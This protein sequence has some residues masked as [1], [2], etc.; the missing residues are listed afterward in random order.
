MWKRKPKR[1]KKMTIVVTS[2]NFTHSRERNVKTNGSQT[3]RTTVEMKSIS[4]A[5][6]SQSASHTGLLQHM[7]FN[8]QQHSELP[9]IFCHIL[10]ST[11]KRLPS[12]MANPRENL[13]FENF[14]PHGVHYAIFLEKSFFHQFVFTT[15]P[16]GNNN[17]PWK[18]Q[19][20]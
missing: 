15:I 4:P 1:C 14:M 11:F 19:G 9:S 5:S 13:A 18:C 7:P 20:F 8:L 6:V 2:V 10:L 17:T 12:A 16:L 3:L